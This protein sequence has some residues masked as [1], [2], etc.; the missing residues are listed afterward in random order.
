MINISELQASIQRNCD[1][2]DAEYGQN[3]GLCIY[4]LKMRDYYRWQKEIPL[5]HDLDNDAIHKWIAETEEHWEEISGDS[6]Q[7]IK[8]NGNLFK[9]FDSGKINSQLIP[10]GLIYSGG[11]GYGGIPL[12]FLAELESSEKHFDFPVK[13]A[14]KEL[15]RGL[16]GSP[17][18][19][20]DNTIYVRKETLKHF[21][22]SRFDEW[23]AIKRDNT[24]GKALS[25]YPFET[26]PQEAI[27][28]ISRYELQTLIQHEIGEG[29]I[30]KEFGLVWAEM[31]LEFA[32]SKTEILLRAVRDL[33]VD[34]MTTLPFLLNEQRIPSIHMYFAGFSDMRKELYPTLYYAYRNWCVSSDP[35]ELN[36]L[37]EKGK[38]FWLRIGEEVIE[39]FKTNGKSSQKS[40]NEYIENLSP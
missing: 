2:I 6:L 9:P 20:L 15:S 22:W 28:Q 31:I 34:C 11:L 24:M 4:L 40:I 32:Y 23:S 10:E 14:G 29:L 1:L 37:I 17:A 27:D 3:Y 8:I 39:Q 26:N 33:V 21:L 18:F 30:D 7:D 36:T 35:G 16:F 25:Y 13:L 38:T 12:F 19:F 5:H